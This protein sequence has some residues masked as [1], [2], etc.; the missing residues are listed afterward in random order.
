MKELVILLINL[1]CCSLILL[2]VISELHP[3]VRDG[4]FTTSARM[5]CSMGAFFMIVKSNTIVSI[6]FAWSVIL[7]FTGVIFIW[8]KFLYNVIYAYKKDEKYVFWTSFPKEFE[9]C[10]TTENKYGRL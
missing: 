8:S 2:S 1:L 10:L 4:F 7:M 5:L 6:D 3:N 9:N